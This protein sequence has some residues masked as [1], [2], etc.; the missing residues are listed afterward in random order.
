MTYK[1]YLDKEDYDLYTIDLGKL[2]PFTS[3]K[4]IEK[5]IYASLEK[6]H[7]C[8]SDYCTFDYVL[9]SE[10]M[11]TIAEVIVVDSMFL[12]EYKN[13]HNTAFIRIQELKSKKLFLSKKQKTLKKAFIFSS[14]TLLFF[15]FIVVTIKNYIIQKKALENI[16][17]IVEHTEKRQSFD[18]S[19]FIY[20]C[21]PLFANPTIKVSYFE[22]TASSLP[23]I[24]LHTNGI[25]REEIEENF[26]GI[27]KDLKLNFSATTYS[28]KT[29]NLSVTVNCDK[30]PIKTAAFCDIQKAFIEI[31]NSIFSVNGL[32]IS[33]AI[34][35]R[36]YQCIVPY[37][38]LQK[39]FKAL[40]EIQEVQKIRFEKIVF[41]YNQEIGNLNCI[42]VLDKLKSEKAL[43]FSNFI[44]AFKKPIEQP[45]EKTVSSK[46]QET[47]TKEDRVLV[48]KM[49]AADGSMILYYRTSEGKIIYE[50]E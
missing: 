13:S 10:K 19:D 6:L 26:L 25:Q 43:D 38:G 50:K 14:I 27:N 1:K 46:K 7:P 29:P 31:R 41:D 11:K 32:P 37:N 39:F 42:I 34:E 48:G 28:D 30:Q 4:L 12:I 2:K 21:M 35:T 49:P 9:K 22:Y 36:Q 5:K 33:E 3:S 44:L 45:K 17:R 16:P 24:T 20:S 47:I 23:Q 18:I 40:L 15:S 8:F